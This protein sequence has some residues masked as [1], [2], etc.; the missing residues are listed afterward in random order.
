MSN[1]NDKT[2]V[3]EVVQF[4]PTDMGTGNESLVIIY[5]PEPGLLG[6]RFLLEGYDTF[7]IGRVMEADLVLEGDSVSRKHCH[8]KRREDGWHLVDDGSTN[9]TFLNHGMVKG[10]ALIQS[11]DRFKVGQTIGKFLAGASAESKYHEEIYRMTIIDGLTQAFNKRYLEE[12]LRREVARAHRHSH[13][14][15]L[16]MFDIDHFKRINDERGHLAGDNVLRELCRYVR[17]RVRED[18]LFAR[19]GGEEFS[20]LLPE[21]DLNGART[22]AA[23]LRAKIA[24]QR[25]KVGDKRFE[26]TVSMGVSTLGQDDTLE[27]LIEN[28]DAKLYEAKNSGRNRVCA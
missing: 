8:F 12:Q 26:I 25:F 2:R 18:E 14:L 11:G 13:P 28:A 27:N 20:I 17:G 21:T 15:S 5:S 16:I 6:K 1:I 4:P 3:T 9:G 19:Y 24:E 7:T 10:S 22:M 23:D